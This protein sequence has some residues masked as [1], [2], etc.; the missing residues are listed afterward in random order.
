[1][2]QR[3]LLRSSSDKAI[4]GVCSGIGNYLGVDPTVIRVI[5]ALTCVLAG[6]GLLA[7]LICALLIPSD[8]DYNPYR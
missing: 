6:T 7:Y 1:M 3:K 8:E 5:W 4:A 2:E